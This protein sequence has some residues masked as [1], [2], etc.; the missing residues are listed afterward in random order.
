MIKKGL[1]RDA[2]PVFIHQ[3]K[4]KSEADVRVEKV[5]AL[6][7]CHARETNT[8]ERSCIAAQIPKV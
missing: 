5:R 6:R 1:W 8:F 2:R 4:Q 7:D 3:P